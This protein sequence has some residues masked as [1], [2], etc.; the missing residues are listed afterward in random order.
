ML[1]IIFLKKSSSKNEMNVMYL[2]LTPIFKN[3]CYPFFVKNEQVLCRYINCDTCLNYFD[4]M[5][6]DKK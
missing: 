6:M 3:K 1:L 4:S 5:L 2:S